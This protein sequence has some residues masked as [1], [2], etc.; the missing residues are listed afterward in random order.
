MA[1]SFPVS[2]KGVLLEAGRVMLIENERGE[3]ERPGGRPQARIRHST[4][5]A[6]SLKSWA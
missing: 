2:I 3:W 1:M 6:N 4:S 5:H